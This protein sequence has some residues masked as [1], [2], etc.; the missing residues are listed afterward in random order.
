M[1]V[2]CYDWAAALSTYFNKIDNITDNQHFKFD[3]NKPGIVSCAI[4]IKDEYTDINILKPGVT[5]NKDLEI[6]EQVPKGLTLKRQWY[7]YKEIREFCSEG[8]EDIIA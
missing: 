6:A 7:L 2:K 1:D 5:F 8:T 3:A 4:D